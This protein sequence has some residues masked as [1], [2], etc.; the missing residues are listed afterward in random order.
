MRNIWAEIAALSGG[1]TAPEET[2][3][4]RGGI[5]GTGRQG[6][7]G[8]G[9]SARLLHPPKGYERITGPCLGRGATRG[10]VEYRRKVGN[11]IPAPPAPAAQVGHAQRWRSPGPRSARAGWLILL[12]ARRR[13]LVCVCAAPRRSPPAPR[14]RGARSSPG[15][16]AA[17]RPE[18]PGSAA[19]AVRRL[20]AALLLLP[21][22]AAVEGERRWGRG[23][24]VSAPGRPLTRPRGRKV[25]PGAGA[26]RRWPQGGVAGGHR[27]GGRGAPRAPG[28]AACAD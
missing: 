8:H 3:A 14:A 12:A 16:P 26:G 22:L 2:T 21:L 11:L 6:A 23:A 25:C 24:A 10:H 7:W 5:W 27:W 4:A 19:M 18:A 28:R 20:G 9:V 1:A 17:T 13:R 15:V